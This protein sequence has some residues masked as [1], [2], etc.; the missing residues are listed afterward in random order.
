M[1]EN[2]QYEGVY[3]AGGWFEIHEE[4][5]PGGWIATDSPEWIAR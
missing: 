3:C 5:N 1:S 4:G 2:N